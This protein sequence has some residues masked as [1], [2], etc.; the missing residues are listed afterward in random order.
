MNSCFAFY[1]SSGGC[2][3]IIF[4]RLSDKCELWSETK[5]SNTFMD[6]ML[7]DLKTFGGNRVELGCT[8]EWLWWIKFK[9]CK[10]NWW[11]VAVMK[12][13]LY[14]IFEYFHRSY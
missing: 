1:V 4:R 10:R 14:K 9:Y 6:K 8:T 3:E 2:N 12:E 5:V 11:K 7:S 13:Q